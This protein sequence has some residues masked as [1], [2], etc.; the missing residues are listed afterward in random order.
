M[1]AWPEDKG[2]AWS[3]SC[4]RD[5]LV[6]PTLKPCFCWSQGGHSLW[7]VSPLHVL[8]WALHGFLIEEVSAPTSLSGHLRG[9]GKGSQHRQVPAGPLRLAL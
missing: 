8:P 9:T 4:P 6:P 2:L 3:G 7:C 5:L 1:E